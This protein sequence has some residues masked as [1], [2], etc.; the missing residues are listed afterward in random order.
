MIIKY[1]LFNGKFNKNNKYYL[2]DKFGNKF[3]VIRDNNL[4]YVY[5]FEQLKRDNINTYYDMGINYLRKNSIF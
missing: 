1:D 4:T 5:N 2:K 3:R